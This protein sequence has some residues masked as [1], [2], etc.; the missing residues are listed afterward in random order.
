MKMATYMYVNKSGFAKVHQKLLI[1]F[2]CALT[3]THQNEILRFT[4]YFFAQKL[5]STTELK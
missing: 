2:E 1:K 3:F 4:F 5:I